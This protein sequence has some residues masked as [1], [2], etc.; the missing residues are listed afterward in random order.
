MLHYGDES[1]YTNDYDYLRDPE[2][3]HDCRWMHRPLID[4]ERQKK[5]ST[6]GTIE[7][8]IFQGTQ[9][10]L[11]LRRKIPAVADLNNTRWMDC[12]NSQVAAYF[13][14]GEPNSL[15]CFFNFSQEHAVVNWSVMG[16]VLEQQPGRCFE[17]Y[18]GKE[19]SVE[20]LNG[21]LPLE[22]YQFLLLDTAH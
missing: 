13:R 4:W 2:K 18:S 7:Y 15:C 16:Q 8:R 20:A 5:V 9:R 11:E 22:P 21:K 17:H 3:S 10:L 14:S 19:F 6:K 12:Q 1:G